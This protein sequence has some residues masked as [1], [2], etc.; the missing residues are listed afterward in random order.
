MEIYHSP[1]RLLGVAALFLLTVIIVSTLAYI[2]AGWN[3]L[4]A[5]YMVLLTVSTV[6]YG[7]VHPISTPYLHAVTMGTIGLGWLGMVI[8]SSALVQFFTVTQLQQLIGGNRTMAQIE[9]LASHVIVVGFGRIGGVLAKALRTAQAD[10]VVLE[11]DEKKAEAVRELGYLCLVGD[12]TN[13]LALRAAGVERARVLASV[14]PNDAA[15][16]FITLSARSLN[17][18]IEIIARGEVPATEGKLLQAGANK[19]VMP[20][21][22]GAERIAEMILFPETARFLRTSERMQ[23]LEFTLRGLGVDFV[24]LVVPEKGGVVGLTIEQVERKAE[25]RFFIVQ[26]DRRAG[27]VITAPRPDTKL[28]PG[29]GVAII[30]KDIPAA[31]AMFEAPAMPVRAG[32][33]K[34]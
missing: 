24:V 6:G 8:F 16:V 33:I 10:F 4:D 32:R 22:I 34:F 19:V 30:S 29:D 20:T 2:H 15:N 31:R 18:S 3:I 17:R 21:H 9:K 13:E 27:D 12:A 7:E 11:Q 1:I 14:L 26:V 23:E 25:N 5:S 28:F